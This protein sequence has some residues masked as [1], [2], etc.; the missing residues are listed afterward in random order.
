MIIERRNFL[1]LVLGGVSLLGGKATAAPRVEIKVY[2]DPSCECCAAWV[3]HLEANGFSA[4]V[5]VRDDLPA[6]KRALGVPDALTSCHTATIHDYVLEGHVPA[7]EIT[8]LL[9]EKPKARGLAVPGMPIG[10]P[11]MEIADLAAEPY[12][13]LLLLNDGSHEIFASYS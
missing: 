4:R 12:E 8:R 3:R 13:V 6:L 5:E 11:G 2:K 1:S 7:R 9:A 10:A